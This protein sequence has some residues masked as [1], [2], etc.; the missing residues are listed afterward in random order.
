MFKL[1]FNRPKDWV[2][3]QRVIRNGPDLDTDSIERVLVE[4]R[5]PTRHPR[6]ARLRAM[7]RSGGDLG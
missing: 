2:D 1:S 5:G 3:V 4:M 6:V 7:I